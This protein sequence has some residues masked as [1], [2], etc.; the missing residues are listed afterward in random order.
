LSDEKVEIEVP[1]QDSNEKPQRLSPGLILAR[2]IIVLV[3]FVFAFRAVVA[4]ANYIPTRSMVPTL[5]QGDKI[6]VDK[7]SLHFGDLHRGDIVIF[8]P[9][10]QPNPQGMSSDGTVVQPKK[11]RFI[12][13]LIGLPGESIE[14]V[15]GV[16]VFV[17][18]KLLDEPYAR[19]LPD[20][21]FGPVTVPDGRLFLL[22]DNRCESQDSHV[23]GTCPG[24]N[25]IGRA[26][27]RY[28]PVLRI[29]PIEDN[30][31][32]SHYFAEQIDG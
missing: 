32:R 10:M 31:F 13:R 18:G 19:S 12:K 27:F 20:Y 25:V 30:D 16:G 29:G 7:I 6:I 21:N 26:L 3:A 9:P 28:W 2:D 22:G 4:E 24:E 1:E 11:V 17:D 5:E 23:W 8:Y 14:V 15:A